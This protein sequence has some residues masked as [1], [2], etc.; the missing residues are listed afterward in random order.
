MGP[1]VGAGGGEGKNGRGVGVWR[2]QTVQQHVQGPGDGLECGHAGPGRAACFEVRGGRVEAQRHAGHRWRAVV[3][4]MDGARLAGRS[5]QGDGRGQRTRL[6]PV[7][8]HQC[9]VCQDEERFGEVGKENLDDHENDRGAR[10]PSVAVGGVD[11]WLRPEM[12]HFLE[13]AMIA[14]DCWICAI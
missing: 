10:E 1:G 9:G 4:E 5:T 13:A 6:R 12:N 8:R 11:E 7:V 14:N 3:F 2:R